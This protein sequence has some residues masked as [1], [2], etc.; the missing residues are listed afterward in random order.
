ME[1]RFP[2]GKCGNCCKKLGEGEWTGISLFAWER[3]LFPE[4]HV[5]PSLGLGGTPEDPDFKVILYLY[6]SEGCVHLD[7][8]SCLIH[9]QRPV[10]CKSYPFRMSIKGTDRRVYEVAPECTAIKLWP[11]ESTVAEH[12][13]E[14]DAAEL[15]GDHLQRF[16]RSDLP[17]WRYEKDRWVEIGKG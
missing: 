17:K 16:Y 9:D 6:D 7:D 4:E 13:E 14:M 11:T 15:I 3:H 12:Y 2:C 8:D 10:I 5:K 1:N